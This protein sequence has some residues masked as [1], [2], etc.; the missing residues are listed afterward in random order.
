MNLGNGSFSGALGLLNEDVSLNGE[1]KLPNNYNLPLAYYLCQKIDFYFY[2]EPYTELPSN[3]ASSQTVGSRFLHYVHNYNIR[4]KNSSIGHVFYQ[5]DLTIWSWIVVFLLVLMI[6][7]NLERMKKKRLKFFRLQFLSNSIINLMRLLIQARVPA[8]FLKNK[9]RISAIIT[10]IGFA[11]VTLIFVNLIKTETLTVE[12]GTIINSLSQIVHS[13]ND[14]N[15]TACWIRSDIQVRSFEKAKEG[16]FFY[17]FWHKYADKDRCFFSYQPDS[18]ATLKARKIIVFTDI[19]DIK[20]V[21]SL[22]CTQLM[23]REFWISTDSLVEDLETLYST[24]KFLPK[25]NE[26]QKKFK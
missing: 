25:F 14:L 10:L 11:Q 7:G 6:L 22:L 4:S 12:T 5:F 13:L 24:K 2:Y 9:F 15:F 17:D 19:Y 1:L 26:L 20:I 23:F 3:V 8:Y 16:E 21:L 18:L